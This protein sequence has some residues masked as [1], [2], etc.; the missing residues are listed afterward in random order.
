MQLSDLRII[1]LGTP[2]FAA[3][4]LQVLLEANCQVVAVITNR[5]KPMGRGFQFQACPVKKKAIENNIPILCPANLNNPAFLQEVRAYKADLQVVVAFRMLPEVLWNMPPLGTINMH[6]SYLP[7]YRGAAPIQRVIMDGA[8]YTGVSTFQL[9]NEIDTGAILMRKKIPLSPDINGG[10][11]HNLLM[12]AGSKLLLNTL[13][14]LIKGELKP[15]EQQDLLQEMAKK[16]PLLAPKIT[17]TDCQIN[18]NLDSL[19][20]ARQVRAL[21]PSPGAFTVFQ[22]QK[23]KIFQVEASIVA[24]LAETDP[25]L[26]A[27]TWKIIKNPLTNKLSLRCFTGNG[28]LDVLKLQMAGKKVMEIGDFL[29]GRPNMPKLGEFEE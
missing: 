1:F 16:T 18:W 22:G 5:D 14:N 9:R 29:N 13:E 3:Y 8:N 10:E 15:I 6:A 27:G 26:K 28:F 23:L 17:N 11:L 25:Q 12:Q 21:S 2:E 7:D 24:G 20:I 4:H 19:V